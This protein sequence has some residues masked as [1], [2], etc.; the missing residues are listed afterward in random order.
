MMPR[1]PE[2]ELM[3]RAEQAKAYAEADFEAPNSAFLALFAERFPRFA[4]DALLDLGCGPGDIA[5]RFARRY[6]RLTVHGLDGAA[7][8]LAH[9]EAALARAPELA[10]RVRFLQ[11]R[12][13]GAVLP[14]RYGA[15]VSNSLLHHLHDPDVLWRAVRA[16][17]AP[18]GCVCVM[19]LFRPGSEDAAVAIVETYAAGEPEILRRDF[20]A[21][22]LAAFTPGEVRD[23]LAAAGLDGLE[24]ETV[25]DRHLLV[26]GRLP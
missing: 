2:P 19:D 12:L 16:A 1:R 25:S 6:P 20:H 3:D 7:A 11:G 21:S 23:Q 4:G 14:R 8:M 17:V 18:G 24:V 9:A 22:L 13:P 5:L 26:S 15:V 10:G